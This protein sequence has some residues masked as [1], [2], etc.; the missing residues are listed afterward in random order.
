MPAEEKVKV[1]HVIEK[2][3]MKKMRKS[4]KHIHLPKERFGYGYG[5]GA[6]GY[7]DAE[8]GYGDVGYG[9]GPGPYGIED[10]W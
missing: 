5:V 7:G 3:P 1:V 9:Y 8:Y 2:K 4:K 10:E 6:Y